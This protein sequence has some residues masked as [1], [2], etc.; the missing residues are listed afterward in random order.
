EVVGRERELAALRV[1]F[2]DPARHGRPIW[3]V[4]AGLGGVGK[5]SLARAYAQ[6]YQQHYGLVWWVRAEDREAVAGEFRALLD[7]LRPHYAEHA[8]DPVQAVHAIL[9]N[10]TDPW[11]LVLDNIAEPEALRGLLPAAGAGDVLVTSRAGTWPDRHVVLPV[12]PLASSHAVHLIMS[13]SG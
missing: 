3:R 13:L 1:T 5:T 9:A 7:I 4:L 8:H 11:L 6:R 10:R 12:G 2:T